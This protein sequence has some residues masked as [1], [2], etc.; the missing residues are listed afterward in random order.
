MRAKSR[1]AA[2]NDLTLGQE[3]F[4][5]YQQAA[6]SWAAQHL[7]DEHRAAYRSYAPAYSRSTD[8]KFRIERSQRWQQAAG[9]ADLAAEDRSQDG[10]LTNY[11]E[12]RRHLQLNEEPRPVEPHAERVYSPSAQPRREP[13]ISPYAQLTRQTDLQNSG[14]ALLKK[15]SALLK[16]PPT[17]TNYKTL[18]FERPDDTRLEPG[19]DGRLHSDGADLAGRAAGP[20]QPRGPRDCSGNRKRFILQ[21]LKKNAGIGENES[22]MRD[23]GRKSIR[24]RR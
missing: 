13:G 21:L 16:N 20:R 24:E 15:T 14:L 3:G 23:G 22:N 7:R 10:M 4:Q 6:T 19:V 1:N 5:T 12:I 17:I 18:N 2:P 9:P 11:Q 8:Q